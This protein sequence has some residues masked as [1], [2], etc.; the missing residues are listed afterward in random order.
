MEGGLRD[1]SIGKGDAEQTGNASSDTKEEDV[2]VETSRF[3]EGKFSALGD[4]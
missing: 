3:T 4:K 2:P 1:E